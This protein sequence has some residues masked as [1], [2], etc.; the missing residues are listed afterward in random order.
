MATTSS[1]CAT[2]TPPVYNKGAKKNRAVNL[3][4]EGATP[5]KTFVFERDGAPADIV[6]A[7]PKDAR[8]K[9]ATGPILTATNLFGDTSPSL[10]ATK[11]SISSP[12]PPPPP[13]TSMYSMSTKAS[14]PSPSS[15]LS[16]NSH[17][18]RPPPPPP[19]RPKTSR[20][21]PHPSP[22]EF[23]DYVIRS[24]TSKEKLDN[25]SGVIYL[26]G[27]NNEDYRLEGRLNLDNDDFEEGGEGEKNDENLKIVA[28]GFWLFGAAISI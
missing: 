12:L 28:L 18:I 1:C 10:P 22:D 8:E 13:S 20:G 4:S 2:E 9:K 23:S 3:G 5:K 14:P 21:H 7:T 15:S 16:T 17:L 11:S 19:A 24:P 6:S 27:N 26:H 25:P